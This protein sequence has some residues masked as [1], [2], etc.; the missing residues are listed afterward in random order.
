MGRW[1]VSV[2]ATSIALIAVVAAMAFVPPRAAWEDITA[3]R[4]ARRFLPRR[5]WR[6]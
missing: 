2:V 6:V 1:P 5:R 4:R 3:G